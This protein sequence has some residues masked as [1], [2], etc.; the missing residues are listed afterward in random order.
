MDVFDFRKRLIRDYR[1]YIESFIQ[2]K[3]PRIWD[4]VHKVLDE[5]ELWPESLIQLNPAFAHGA[6]IDE[7]VQ[8]NTLH[9]LCQ[10]IFRRKNDPAD[11]GKPLR[12][13]LHQTQAIDTAKTGASYVLTT[14]TGSGKSLAYI[15]PIVDAVLCNGPGK[16]IKAIIIYPMNALA[17]SQCGELEKFIQWGFAQDQYPLRF[18]KYTGQENEDQR[19]A[20]IQN[21][22]DILLTNYVMLELILTRPE[23]R[24]LI[25]AARN[26]QFLVLDELHSYR[27]RQGADVSLL[28]RRVRETLGAWQ[29]QCV[30]TSATLAGEGTF[31]E[32]QREVAKVASQLFGIEVKPEH[33]IGETLQRLTPELD[34]SQQAA[35]T[36]LVQQANAE[37]DFPPE[38]SQFI[39]QPLSS[40]LESTFGVTTDPHSGRLVRARPCAIGG[41]EG[42]AQ[43]L[44]NLTGL[45]ASHCARVI[46]EALLAGNR[47]TPLPD[48][49]I[50]P[51]V[52]RLHQFISRGDTVHA[53]L[54][55]EERRH[56]TLYGQQ[57][58]P[59]DREKILLPLAFCRECG[60]E[61]YTVYLNKTQEGP[62]VSPRG[63]N[64]QPL[65]EEQQAGF[66]YFSS[67]NPWNE[68][69]EDLLARLPEEW[70]EI[71]AGQPDV[72]KDR[73]PKLP[74]RLPLNSRGQ[75]DEQGMEFYYINRPFSFCLNCGVAYGSR[76]KSD[77]AKLS[78][79]S[80]EGRSTATTILSM[81]TIHY[82]KQAHDLPL[83]ARKLL[84]FTDNRQDASLQ[85]GHFND[86]IEIGVL[87]AALY[88]AASN[89][90]GQGLRHD[91]LTHMVFQALGLQPL[92]WAI[93]P[94]A[95][96]AEKENAEKAFRN[97]LGYRL[98]RDLLR[99]WR[100]TS[101][102]LEQCGLLEIRYTS[103]DEVCQAEDLWQ[104]RH[105]A[106]ASAA[107]E[108][109]RQVVKVLLDFMRR[110]LAIKVDYLAAEF[111]ERIQQ[112]SNQ[113]L[114]T[115]WALD[116]DEKMERG[117]I[118]FPRS[119][120]DAKAW[121]QVYLSGRSGFSIYLRRPNTFRQFNQK[122]TLD[123]TERIIRDL[124]AI[125]AQAGLVIAVDVS[126]PD[127]PGYQLSAAAMTWHAGDGRR[128]FQDPIRVPHLPADGGR[129]NP[130][131]LHYYQ[132]MAL[133]TS[134]F[135]AREHTA[136][137]PNELRQER[138]QRFRMAQLPILYCSP[139]M[140][141]GVDIDELNVVNMRNVP[142][143]PANYA[144]RSGRAGRSGQPAVVFTYCTTGSPHD[145]YF[146][147]RPEL[148]VSGQVA[149]PRMDLAN[150][151]LIKAHI[152]AIWLAETRPRLGKSL[153]DIL[154]LSGSEPALALMNDVL[155]DLSSP[156][157]L[158]RTRNKAE[159]ILA[160]I[161]PELE[162]SDWYHPGWLEEVLA[163]ALEDFEKA[164]TRWREL[165]RTALAQAKAQDKVIRDA[166]RPQA[167][168]IRAERLRREAESQLKLLTEIENVVQSDFYVYRY[169]A[170]E[171]FLPGYSFPRLPLSA[172]VPGRRLK[173]HDEFL[174]RPRFL[175][176]SE[177]GPRAF[178]YHE[179]S[180]Y[181]INR[182]LLT[183]QGDVLETA[184]AKLCE[185][186]G[187]LHPIQAGVGPDLC[188][189]CHNPLDLPLESLLRLQNVSTRR[190]DRI[191]SDE[192]ERMRLG[193]E[194]LTAVRFQD[195]DGRQAYIQGEIVADG[196][197]LVRVKYG[198]TATIWRI[199]LGWK[200]RKNRAQSGFLL[201]IDKGYW[202]KNENIPADEDE[203]LTN[204]VQR[205]R[206]FVEDRRNSLIL[207]M[208]DDLDIGQ[209]ASLQAALKSAIQIEYQLEDQELAVEPLPDTDERKFILLYEAAEG[210]AGVLRRLL[211]D[212]G[213]FGA[214]AARA[215]ELCHFDPATGQDLLKAPRAKENCEA[216]CYDCLMSYGNQPDHL[217]LDRKQIRDLL[218]LMAG[219]EVKLSP[220]ATSREQHLRNLASL[221]GS[222]LERQ[223]L[224]LLQEI[225][226]RLPSHA[227]YLIEACHTRPDFYYQEHY[228]AVYIDGPHH[229]YPERQQRDHEQETALADRGITVI[230]FGHADDW[231][232]ILGQY[233][234]IFG[235]MA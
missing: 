146:F 158:V 16:G 42:S 187:Y 210:G 104:E 219:A 119:G 28:L 203:N 199:N 195:Q 180:R 136:Q 64:D 191:T 95:R 165:Y 81:S 15:I 87:R 127:C 163:H 225:N 147:K 126:E 138:E 29:M 142:P 70:L 217:L 27:G 202:E 39:R 83:K 218:M 150:E 101:P 123:E 198:H 131:F 33:V 92:A 229:E 182:V 177:F 172:Y 230:R 222:E 69:P 173:Q 166:T 63:L 220:L 10:R 181:D 13:H 179:G 156:E 170:S 148:M 139:T 214:V 14:G 50:P 233:P 159:Q 98:Y 152:H 184:A 52:Y 208:M 79:L 103:L 206:P 223:W 44:A 186:C 48:S 200:R 174:S 36:S 107:L 113:Y 45:T 25:Q 111:Q 5:G 193:Y 86:F 121:G 2:I 110:E 154:D 37:P 196:K 190:R 85:A 188:E 60:Q 140:E 51:F 221:A 38:G 151:D 176:I 164:C 82:L 145:Q 90:G 22:P 73:R 209:M 125:L 76:Q 116:E 56:I 213:A 137:V 128:A 62:V 141:L 216:A 11:L 78:T 91:D 227:Q 183:M 35:C 89:A 130:Y 31:A 157:A 102:N 205:V 234:Y 77:Y 47:C 80:S 231:R 53:S 160:G 65:D 41:E 194:L 34:F 117:M 43:R 17:N 96:F 1:D 134:G 201:D 58:V 57:F 161:R 54:E 20:I 169:F 124:L 68:K 189:N 24:G 8:N 4:H 59:G 12:L 153:K 235:S 88:R 215:L 144:Q 93:T 6:W 30:G 175:A 105:P 224:R 118:L 75:F 26:L 66:L 23:E 162:N 129:T 204:R 108:E 40:W 197:P 226:L 132:E 109:R 178:I 120:G 7:L 167:E 49:A 74:L 228:A 212:P 135:E 72:R 168:R 133:Q 18:A 21:P 71:R 84:S 106:L 185:H 32:Q 61:Y 99:G 9:P 19:K 207:Q 94:G 115:P 112:Q 232:K 171:G 114:I 192:E 155:A 149:P 122:L 46:K 211:T 100:I 3:D 97:V 143:T 67:A 55:P